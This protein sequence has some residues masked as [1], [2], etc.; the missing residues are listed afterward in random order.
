MDDR[1][2]CEICSDPATNGFQDIQETEPGVL[3]KNG[4]LW[5]TFEPVPNSQHYY[6]TSHMR[7]GGRVIRIKRAIS[8]IGR[9]SELGR[10]DR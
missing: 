7:F 4:I 10:G 1:P 3:D 8:N 9:V 6:C 5:A 2:I